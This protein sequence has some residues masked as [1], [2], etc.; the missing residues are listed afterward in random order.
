[1]TRHIDPEQIQAVMNSLLETVQREGIPMT[2]DQRVAP[3]DAAK[4][5]GLSPRTLKNARSGAHHQ[6]GPAFRRLPGPKG[7]RRSYALQDIAQWQARQ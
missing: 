2:P 5:L 1:M 6:E 3:E 7:G 4:L